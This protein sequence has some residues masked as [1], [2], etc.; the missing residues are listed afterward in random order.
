MV[1]DSLRE[2]NESIARQERL[3]QG[4]MKEIIR[5]T[6]QEPLQDGVPLYPFSHHSLFKKYE[7]VSQE[8]SSGAQIPLSVSTCI[9]LPSQLDIL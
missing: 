4:L 3:L 5:L 8:E 2:L 7:E 6:G 1:S 9:Q